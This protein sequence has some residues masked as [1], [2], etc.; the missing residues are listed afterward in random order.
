MY[1]KYAKPAAW[2]RGFRMKEKRGRNLECGAV[3]GF[4]IHPFAG[5]VVNEWQRVCE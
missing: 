4:I 3:Y 2:G 5:E 1:A